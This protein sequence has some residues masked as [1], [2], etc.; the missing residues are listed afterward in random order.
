M[1]AKY[2]PFLLASVSIILGLFGGCELLHQDFGWADARTARCSQ[3]AIQPIARGKTFATW[4]PSEAA[5]ERGIVVRL[6]YP[7]RP[8]YPEGTAAVVE[9]PG[10][11]SPGGVDLPPR[12]FTDPFVTQGLIQVKFAFPG[13]GRP[14]L[15][16]GGTYDHRGLDSL[17]A[18]RDVVRF[19]RGELS[20]QN[21]CSINDL[22]PYEIAQL[23]LI[24]P[25]NGGNTAIVAL[26]LFAE[27]MDVDWYVGWENPAGTQFATVDL[28]SRDQ[29]NPA[30]IPGSCHMTA[31]GAQCDVDYSQLRFDPQA[32]QRGH[33]PQGRGRRGVLYHDLNGNGRYDERDYA[34]GTYV[35]I[36]NGEEKL[37]YSLPGLEAAVERDLFNSWPEGAATAE[38]T[39]G[40]WQIRD[41][42]RYYDDV[43]ENRP[44]LRVIVIGS[45]KDHV[46]GTPDYP[47]IALQYQ[48]W[49]EAGITWVRLNP[50]AVY[51]EAAVG[52][53]LPVT[54]NEANMAADYTNI[55][56]LVEPEVAR[57][58]DLRLA[59]ALE[60][61]D[62]MYSN[63]WSANLDKKLLA[64]IEQS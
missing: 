25:S 21:G 24:G 63:T 12:G 39:R 55:V 1:K 5:P 62:R 42:S 57:D 7:D 46:Q 47:H 34:L 28:G 41:M 10:G 2:R 23:G 20:E 8:R 58:E 33:P 50:D 38:E 26:G 40:Y 4:I 35:G 11:D 36:F 18:V 53:A 49:Q 44:E 9:V 14:S 6:I 30:Y 19:L 37:V 22:L 56:E 64:G 52:R 51:V 27:E 29:S 31:E 45:R 59:A 32:P 60:L 61:S 54:D 15:A 13:G 48:G 16:S 3:P 43:M 17:R